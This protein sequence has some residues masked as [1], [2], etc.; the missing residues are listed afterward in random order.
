MN[1][2]QLIT[3]ILGLIITVWGAWYI[4]KYAKRE[5]KKEMEKLKDKEEL[6]IN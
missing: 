2:V 5:I 3:L 6:N 4:T 1:I